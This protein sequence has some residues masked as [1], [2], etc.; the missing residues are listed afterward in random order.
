MGAGE[1]W[2]T[3]ELNPA[4]ELV[5]AGGGCVAGAAEREAEGGAGNAMPGELCGSLSSARAA[6]ARGRGVRPPSMGGATRRASLDAVGG[7]AWRRAR[8]AGEGASALGRA[9]AR[10]GEAHAGA[11]L[12]RLRPW[13]RSEAAA[14]EGGKSLFHLYF[15]GIFK[16]HLSNI[17]FSKKM[18]SFENSPRMKV[19]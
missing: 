14:R 9:E 2:W 18:T 1:L 4:R 6:A 10:R 15:Q 17:I 13:A 7:V 19:A 3:D 12:G 5:A 11:S 8:R 16:C